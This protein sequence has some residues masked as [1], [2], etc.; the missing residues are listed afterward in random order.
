MESL[1]LFAIDPLAVEESTQPGEADAQQHEHEERS[2]RFIPAEHLSV[3][4]EFL[5]AF[6]P[7]E[8][9]AAVQAAILLCEGAGDLDENTLRV[10]RVDEGAFPRSAAAVRW[11]RR[12]LESP[13]AAWPDGF[14][15]RFLLG[16]LAGEQPAR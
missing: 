16:V 5:E 8:P 3:A 10:I 7:D 13:H 15:P 2:R 1:R 14:W 11:T 9:L 6:G 12:M 4:E